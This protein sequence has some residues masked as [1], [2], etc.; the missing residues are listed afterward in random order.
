ML[1]IHSQ[2]ITKTDAMKLPKDDYGLPKLTDLELDTLPCE[3]RTN[4]NSGYLMKL[5]SVLA[6]RKLISERAKALGQTLP[7]RRPVV[8]TLPDSHCH[9]KDAPLIDHQ[10]TPPPDAH[11]EDPA[12][13]DILWDGEHI[14]YSNIVLHDACLLYCARRSPCT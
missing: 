12:P 5:Y 14:R 9:P 10:Y 4:D 1:S 7:P 3:L 11:P 2:T 8:Y 6:V 13:E